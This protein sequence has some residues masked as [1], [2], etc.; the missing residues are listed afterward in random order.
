M[1]KKS[2]FVAIV[3]RTLKEGKTFEDYRR[4]WFH[5]KGFGVP[6]T[7]YTVINTFNPREIISIGIL[8]AGEEDVLNLLKIDVED[9]LAN[10]LDDVI[11]KTI[12][13]QFGII[14][15]EDDFSPAGNLSYVPAQVNGKI[16]DFTELESDLA[17]LA[18]MIKQASEERDQRKKT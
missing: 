15:A 6:T 16:T 8:E 2:K 18:N 1:S 13:R 5:T 17:L 7:M 12:I 14:V 9:R 3:T 10:P 11:E 4:A